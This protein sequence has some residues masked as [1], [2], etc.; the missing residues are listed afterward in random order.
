MELRHFQS[1][2]TTYCTL[3][4]WSSH[5]R[6]QGSNLAVRPARE[7]NRFNGEVHFGW[8]RIYSETGLQSAH[9]DGFAYESVPN[10]PIITGDMPGSETT[11]SSDLQ[12]GTLGHLAIG[13]AGKRN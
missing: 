1:E 5:C 4:G 8:A 6:Y 7:L 2:L 11:P 10:R 12:R 3:T 9:L 13:A